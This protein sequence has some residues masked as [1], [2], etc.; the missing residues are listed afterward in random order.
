MVDE[1]VRRETMDDLG[2]DDDYRV[3]DGEVA[4]SFHREA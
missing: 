3:I 4:V 2:R 1:E